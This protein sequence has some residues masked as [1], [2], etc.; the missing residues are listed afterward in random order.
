MTSEKPTGNK[1][2]EQEINSKITKADISKSLK[3]IETKFGGLVFNFGSN[4]KNR[5]SF[6]GKTDMEIYYKGI[7]A[8]VEIK[9][10]T[11]KLSEKQ[12]TYGLA[13]CSTPTVPYWIA[14][15]NNYQTFKEMILR[16]ARIELIA[17]KKEFEKILLREYTLLTKRK[18]KRK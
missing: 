10:G 17:W 18:N 15:E 12:I 3:E 6:I 16:G 4:R 13:V 8:M 7:L 5:G 2:P 9:I 14:T 11:D 1:S